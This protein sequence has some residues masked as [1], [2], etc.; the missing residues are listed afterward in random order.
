MN[1]FE[2]LTDLKNIL[3]VQKKNV[4]LGNYSIEIKCT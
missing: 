4:Q 1:L 2:M 3:I